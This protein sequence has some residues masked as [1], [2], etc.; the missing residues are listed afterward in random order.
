M[1]Y[2]IT[3]TLKFKKDIRKL[4]KRDKIIISFY[5]KVLDILEKGSFENKIKKLKDVKKDDLGQWRIRVGQYRFRFD[6]EKKKIILKFV[7]H[8]IDSYR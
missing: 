6:I 5:E 3:S 8:R 2:K 4:I 7:G 1:E